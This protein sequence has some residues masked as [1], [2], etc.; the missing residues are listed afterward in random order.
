MNSKHIPSV[1]L[2]VG[3]IAGAAWWLW[4]AVPVEKT[5][6]VVELAPPL[7]EEPMPEPNEPPPPLK[8]ADVPPSPPAFDPQSEL[9]TAIQDFARL[10]QG[11]DMLALMLTYMTP[12][13]Q[14]R[15]GPEGMAQVQ[16]M[17]QGPAGAMMTQMMLADIQ[18]IQNATPTYDETGNRATFVLPPGSTESKAVF[19]RVNGRWYRE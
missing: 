10:A 11:G 9:G 3:L 18:A 1:L 2:I 8:V 17:M 12:D 16:A 7:A 19:V 13:E 6:P 14:A 4:P 5:A 15:M